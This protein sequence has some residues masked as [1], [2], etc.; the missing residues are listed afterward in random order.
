MS[1]ETD[2]ESAYLPPAELFAVQLNRRKRSLFYRRFETVA[3]AVKFAIEEMPK[4][5][6]NVSLEADFGRLDRAEIAALYEAAEFPLER[7]SAGGLV[8]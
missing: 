6:A 3:E 7:G 8:S 4:N 5:S 1:Y 2:R